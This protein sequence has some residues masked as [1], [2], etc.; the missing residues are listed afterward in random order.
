MSIG[1]NSNGGASGERRS[2][3]QQRRVKSPGGFQLDRL[4]KEKARKLLDVCGQDSD[5][6]SLVVLGPDIRHA[7]GCVLVLKGRDETHWLRDMLIRQRLLTAAK[8]IVKD[9]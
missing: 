5:A 3:S 1:L 8:E 9:F 2:R 4:E 7:T 6:A